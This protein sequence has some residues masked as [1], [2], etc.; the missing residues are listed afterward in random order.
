MLYRTS[1]TAIASCEGCRTGLV[2]LLLLA[3]R[4]MLYRTSRTTIATV[5]VMVCHTGLV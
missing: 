5:A 1:R 2:G 3:E 4:V